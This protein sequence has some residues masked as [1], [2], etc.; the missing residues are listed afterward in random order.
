MTA[1]AGDLIEY[2]GERYSMRTE[3]F[4]PFI[5]KHNIEFQW[6]W[7]SCYRG[8]IA[9]WIIEDD[10]LYMVGFDDELN[11][12]PKIELGTYFPNQDKVFADWFS[13]KLVLNS[14]EMLKYIH[15]G[16]CSI[17]ERDI[18]LDVENGVVKSEKIYE[19]REDFEKGILTVSR[20]HNYDDGINP[21]DLF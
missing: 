21:N 1:Q 11:D 7:S 2:K 16:Y 4:R 3:P 20:N 14:G 12:N 15:R 6:Q 17:L 19:N 13:G 10:K 18:V 5:W 8:Y 9:K